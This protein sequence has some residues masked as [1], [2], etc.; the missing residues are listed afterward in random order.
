[1]EN[2]SKFSDDY[3]E[4]LVLSLHLEGEIVDKKRGTY[5]TVYIVKKESF[6]RYVAYKTIQPDILAQIDET[7]LER[8]I[9]EMKQW[10]RVKS[11]PLILTP[12]YV[13]FVKRL[14]LVCMRFCEI[15]LGT[16][17][18]KQGKLSVIEG[19]VITAQILKALMF[20][21]SKGIEA[22]QDLKPANILLEDL[23]N[24]FTGF[25]PEGMPFFRYRVRIADFGNA[26]AWK[27]L[28]KPHGSRPYMAP[29]QFLGKGDYSKVDVFAVGVILYELLTGKHP[30]GERTGDLWPEPKTGFPKKFKHEGPWKK[31]ATEEVKL[32]RIGEDEISKEIENLIH[33]MLLPDP[34]KRIS[35]DEAFQKVIN[36]ISKINND[37]ADYL[38]ILIEYY[39]AIANYHQQSRSRLADLMELSKIPSLRDPILNNML[40]EIADIGGN[41]SAPT[42][43][44]YF[45]KL[46]YMASEL[47]LSR[48]TAKDREKAEEL[49]KRAIFEILKWKEQI[50]VA[51]VYPP[52][53]FREDEIISPPRLRDFDVHSVLLS[54]GTALLNQTMGS[55]QTERF[56]KSTGDK[57]LNALYLYN[58]A[59]DFKDSNL[60]KALELLDKCIELQPTE[61]TLYFRKAL[62]AEL[63]LDV[64]EALENLSE[65]EK[66]KLSDFIRENAERAVQ[67]APDWEEPRDI[68]RRLNRR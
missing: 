25:P 38:N 68:L 48:N 20:C 64:Q 56:F 52:L 55:D 5:G 36:I 2:P 45:I 41:I 9:R 8:F 16:Y 44:V 33:N 24:K 40:E 46:C 28:G 67:L 11:H 12:F 21:K 58:I 3:I 54:V 23:S 66:R 15:D 17:L 63:H 34:N 31:W 18:E 13:T 27:E 1:M 47:L 59:V 43:A 61:P 57:Y 6:P 14:P 50:K 19:L 35:L 42:E 10:F 4:R 32:I 30:I 53:R 22:H 60:E 37:A 7:K 65:N 62:W 26:D 49:A 39:D 51:H 29:E